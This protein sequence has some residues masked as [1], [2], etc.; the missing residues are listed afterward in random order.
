MQ[1]HLENLKIL[2]KLRSF[3]FLLGVCWGSHL[4]RCRNNKTALQITVIT[5]ATNQQLVMEHFQSSRHYAKY[6]NGLFHLLIKT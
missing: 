4:K 5:L 3:I 6:F 1:T 2:I